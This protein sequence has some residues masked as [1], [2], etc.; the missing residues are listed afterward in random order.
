ML[1]PTKAEKNSFKEN[2]LITKTDKI[3]NGIINP[4]EGHRVIP[5]PINM[6]AL[7]TFFL[8]SSLLLSSNNWWVIIIIEECKSKVPLKTYEVLNKLIKTI[9]VSATKYVFL[10]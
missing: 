9:Y 4:K 6:N 3:S 7:K 8:P 2:D 5:I 1:S 10:S